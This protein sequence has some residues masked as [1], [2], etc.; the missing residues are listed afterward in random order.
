M[1]RLAVVSQKGGVGK[2]TLALN[3]SYALAA[4]G[5]RTLVVDAD[6]EGSIGLSI[7]K[8]GENN[9]LLSVL[10]GERTLDDVVVR[11]RLAE[12]GLV[13]AGANGAADQDTMDAHLRQDGALGS[14]LAGIEGAYDFVVI[15]TPAGLRGITR[16]VMRSSTHILSPVQAE[17]LAFRS[18]DRVLEAVAMLREDGAA[19]DLV[20]FV[21]T[22]LQMKEAPSL[23]VAQEMWGSFPSEFILET[24]VSRDAAFLQASAAGVPLALLGRRPPPSAGRFDQLAAEIVSRLGLQREVEQDGP[25]AFLV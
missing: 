10:I 11:T 12:L 16:A 5:W 1:I 18:A 20:G 15:D 6:P 23:A 25:I 22:M 24:M 4:Q 13:L 2:T 3:L 17:P 7:A 14:V 19:L 8:K 9:G 21:V